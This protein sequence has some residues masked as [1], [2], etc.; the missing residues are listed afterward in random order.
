VQTTSLTRQPGPDANR[1]EVVPEVVSMGRRIAIFP[2]RRR[3]L[4]I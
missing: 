2:K 3:T 4:E 1:R